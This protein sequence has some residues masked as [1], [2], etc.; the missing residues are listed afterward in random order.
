MAVLR[1]SRLGARPHP[2]T[3]LD[4]QALRKLSANC[5]AAYAHRLAPPA[6]HVSHRATPRSTTPSQRKRLAAT[7][8]AGFFRPR[9]SLAC[10]VISFKGLAPDRLR[11]ITSLLPGCGGDQTVLCHSIRRSLAQK[12]FTTAHVLSVA[13]SPVPGTESIL[14]KLRKA[15]VRRCACVEPRVV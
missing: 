5:S 4:L 13:I 11:V 3:P 1:W 14:A 2:R 9:A 10:S 12:G 6:S 15:A 7:N 8:R